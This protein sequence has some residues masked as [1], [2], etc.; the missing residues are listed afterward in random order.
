MSGNGLPE[1]PR[2]DGSRAAT[3]ALIGGLLFVS[4]FLEAVFAHSVF[5]LSLFLV[6]LVAVSFIGLV[7]RRWK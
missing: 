1:Q 5:L 2:R 4:G 3:L 7:L 6:Y